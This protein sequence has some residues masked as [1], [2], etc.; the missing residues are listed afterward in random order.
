MKI[1]VLYSH[2]H[3][4]LPSLQKRTVTVV[5]PWILPRFLLIAILHFIYHMIVYEKNHSTLMSALPDSLALFSCHLFAARY[6]N[7]AINP[8]HAFATSVVARHFAK[9]HWICWPLVLL[10]FRMGRVNAQ[11]RKRKKK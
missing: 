8:A 4:F 6:T 7:A 9:V 1:I 5:G 2:K 10:L 11:S 3:S